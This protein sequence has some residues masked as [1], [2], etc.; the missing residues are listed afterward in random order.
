MIDKIDT[1]LADLQS[2]SQDQFEIVSA[3]RTLFQQTETDLT[4]EIK[5]GGLVFVKA[6]SLVGG[7]FPYKSHI[8]I[9]FSNGAEFSDPDR[10]LQGK[11]KLR[12][13]LKIESLADIESNKA[14]G[15]IHQAVNG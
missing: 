13:H 11:G 1:F 12:R 7:I 15:F 14:A 3:I 2:A 4:E 9:E 5:Y 6:G 10:L 8:S